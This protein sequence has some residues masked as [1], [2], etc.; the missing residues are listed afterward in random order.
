M[1]KTIGVIGSG[2]VGQSLAN[3]FLKHGYEVFIGS[4]NPG[5]REELKTKTHGKAQVGTFEEAAKFGEIVVFAVKG[6]AAEATLKTLGQS[7]LG[8][9]P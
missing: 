7:A 2:S 3:G 5:K 9:R 6:S 8:G 1:A 4:N